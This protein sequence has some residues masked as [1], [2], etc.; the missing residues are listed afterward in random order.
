MLL[1]VLTSSLGNKRPVSGSSFGKA[2]KN[3]SSWGSSSGHL[4]SMPRLN[5]SRCRFRDLTLPS[6]TR[7]ESATS[8]GVSRAGKGISSPCL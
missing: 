2:R 8:T 1:M 7:K 6:V 5:L 4:S 3:C